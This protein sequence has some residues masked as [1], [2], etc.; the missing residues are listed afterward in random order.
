MTDPHSPEELARLS[1]LVHN[2]IGA[3]LFALAVILIAE[4]LRGS[5]ASRARFA[6][7]GLGMLIGFGLAIWVFFH[8]IFDHG[9]GP[10]DDPV[11]NQHQAIGWMAGLGSAAELFRRA[12]GPEWLKVGFPLGIVGVGIAFLAHEQHAIEAL[13]VHWALAGTLVLS[14]LATLSALVSGEEAR[15]MRL[16]GAA[17]LLAAAVQLVVYREDPGAHAPTESAPHATHQR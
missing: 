5:P 8:Q 7:P 10:F 16:F 12:G 17:T 14:G 9:L 3:A 1:T 13:V 15:A 11:Q 6:W 2:A 4:L